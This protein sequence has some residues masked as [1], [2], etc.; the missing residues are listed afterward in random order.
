MMEKYIL[1]PLDWDT[2]FF[3][4]SSARVMLNEE[5]IEQE[6]ENMLEQCRGYGFVTIENTCGS[7]VNDY[8]LGA[9]S[10]AYITDCAVTLK[11]KSEPH[12]VNEFDGNSI[13]MAVEEDL[14]WIEEIAKDAFTTSRFYNDPQIPKEKASALYKSWVKNAFSDENKIIFVSN[15][16]NGFLIY[17]QNEGDA[18]L[19][20]I[21]TGGKNHKKGV[22][23]ALTKYADNYAFEKGCEDFYVGTQSANIPAINLYVKCGFKFS[24]AKRIFH[25]RND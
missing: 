17:Y 6:F 16:K 11:K 8:Y 9:K 13:R 25:L 15:E 4:V 12:S 10:K 2:D 24:K 14:P 18:H 1:K 23:T 21:A 20:L 22:G 5:L 3:G 19:N 7:P